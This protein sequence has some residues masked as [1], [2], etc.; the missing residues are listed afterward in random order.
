VRD[1][2]LACGRSAAL[3]ATALA[4]CA[5]PASDRPDQIEFGG[6]R[7]VELRVPIAYEHGVATP[8]LLVLHGYSVSG[9]VEVAYT[10]LGNLVDEETVL[11]LAPDG[12]LDAEGNLFW[13]AEHVGCGLGAGGPNDVGYLLS[14]IDDVATVWSV[15]L[16]RVFVFGH[17]NGGFMAYRLACE[18][19][20]RIAAVISL[21]GAP[22]ADPTDCAA[23][24]PVSILQ[25]HG[26]ADDTVRYE[27]GDEVVGIPCPYAGAE[28]TVTRWAATNGCAATRT[29]GAERLDLDSVLPGAE[30]RVEAHDACPD[31]LAVELWTL[32]GGGHIPAFRNDVHRVL[33]QFFA[34]HPRG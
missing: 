9:A 34:A 26:D 14:L 16:D 15:D 7:P 2:A 29:D 25:I 17:S 8:L 24:G 30:T 1:K 18:R 27:G 13:N 22:A 28:E 3:V 21:A 5:Q 19:A 11:L 6:D 33:W 4:A 32:E 20:D 10:R 12:T 31:G 23:T